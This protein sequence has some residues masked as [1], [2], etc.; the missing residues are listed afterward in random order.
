MVLNLVSCHDHLALHVYQQNVFCVAV[1]EIAEEKTVL[2]SQ[3]CTVYF[4]CVK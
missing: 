4:L 2:G 1:T 3:L